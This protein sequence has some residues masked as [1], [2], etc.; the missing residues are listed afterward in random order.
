MPFEVDIFRPQ[1]LVSIADRTPEPSC[2]LLNSF[3]T[4]KKCFDT[5]MVL[6][7]FE[8]NDRKLAPFVHP[9]VGGEIVPNDSYQIEGYV[10][11][12][13]APER[14]TDVDT[15][16]TKQFGESIYGGM[17]P[18][19]RA[20]KKLI[21]DYTKLKAMIK[22]R[23]E[24]MAAQVLLTGQIDIVG[25]GVSEVID[26]GLSN[27]ETIV[28]EANKWSSPTANPIEDL[29]RWHTEVQKKGHINPNVCI[30]SQNAMQSFISNEFVQKVFD[31][32]AYDL[33]IFKP[34]E[35]DPGVTYV[36]TYRLLNMD[37]YTYNEWYK[38][39][40]TDPDNH[41][42]KAMIPDGK[43]ILLSSNAKYHCCY[44]AVAV[45]DQKTSALDLVAKPIV[46]LTRFV[47]DPPARYVKL[48]SR[49]LPVPSLKN[50]WFVATVM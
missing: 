23:E 27:N 26:F 14:V 4:E 45:G 38:D 6:F 33:A 28:T 44:G 3:F 25:N 31:K 22:R 9:K 11:P 12:M 48:K 15:I 32:T 35:L 42:E 29:H 37:F 30:M 43:V 39:D 1:T 47:E 7:E 34:R 49:P 24:W 41:T 10:P 40:F 50:S 21:E 20:A 8:E 36:G 17:S 16:M 2:F 46:P 13:L 18:K 19:E 5:E